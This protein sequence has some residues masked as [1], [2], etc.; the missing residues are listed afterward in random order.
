MFPLCKI[1]E[2]LISGL[3]F[4]ACPW[5]STTDGGEKYLDMARISIVTISYTVFLAMLYLI[6]KGWNTVIF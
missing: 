3:Y 4:N 2:A 5:V 6:S 1:F